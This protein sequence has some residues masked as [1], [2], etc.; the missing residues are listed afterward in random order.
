[1]MLD[2]SMERIRKT[3]GGNSTRLGVWQYP[4]EANMLL[5]AQRHPVM[6]SG[7]SVG[8]HRNMWDMILCLY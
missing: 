2:T 3:E 4:A 6:Q 7:P 1:M 5:M 8:A